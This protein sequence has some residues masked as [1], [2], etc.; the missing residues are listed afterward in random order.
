MADIL[1]ILSGVAGIV[2]AATGIISLVQVKKVKSLD[3]RMEQGRLLNTIQ[4]N[5]DGLNELAGKANQSRI[6]RFSAQGISQS[7]AMQK[8]NT[9]FE[10]KKNIIEELSQTFS[11]LKNKTVSGAE[12]EKKI[13]D[14][15]L[16]EEQAKSIASDFTSSIA[17]DDIARDRLFRMKFQNQN[18]AAG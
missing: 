14:L 3:L 11:T 5:L 12:L 1:A 16:I 18:K 15:H 8:W 17:E 9:D 4:V 10:K 2:G 13:L 6:Y 7:G